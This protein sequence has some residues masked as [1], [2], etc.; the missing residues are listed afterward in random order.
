MIVHQHKTGKDHLP[1][2]DRLKKKLKADN[3]IDALK[4]LEQID[5]KD[6]KDN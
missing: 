3:K 2:A 5:G 6:K 1:F 4:K